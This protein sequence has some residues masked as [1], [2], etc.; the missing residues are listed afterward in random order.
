MVV[1]RT[2]AFAKRRQSLAHLHSYHTKTTNSSL[3]K[4]TSDNEEIDKKASMKKS[5]KRRKSVLLKK[6]LSTTSRYNTPPNSAG[7]RSTRR[8]SRATLHDTRNSFD[9]ATAVLQAARRA[10]EACSH[11]RESSTIEGNSLQNDND[12]SSNNFYKTNNNFFCDKTLEKSSDSLKSVNSFL[13]SD[14]TT[15]VP[16]WRRRHR[17]SL[18]KK[19]IIN[20]FS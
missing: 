4:R 19:K 8:A 7:F 9:F 5:S 14:T 16:P 1:G 15:Y 12:Y 13:K 17:I 10:S 11:K 2:A 18:P 6:K 20:P 3:V